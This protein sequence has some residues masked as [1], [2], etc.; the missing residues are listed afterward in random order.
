MK[1]FLVSIL[2]LGIFFLA[3]CSKAPEE[4]VDVKTDESPAVSNVESGNN[5]KMNL[6]IDD[7]LKDMPVEFTLKKVDDGYDAYSPNDLA[8]IMFY[9]DKEN[10]DRSILATSFNVIDNEEASITNS[11]IG[12]AYLA[13]TLSG[14]DLIDWL[15]GVLDKYAKDKGIFDSKIVGNKILEVYG[16]EDG[17]LFLDVR[18]KDLKVE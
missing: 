14:E 13:N 16:G 1:S 18:H 17:I 2:T 8:R 10:L 9:G 4:K 15:V 5:L 7:V 3:G 12:V 11:E 6:S